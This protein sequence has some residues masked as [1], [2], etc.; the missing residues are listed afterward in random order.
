MLKYQIN[1]IKK[2]RKIQTEE[3]VEKEEE[4]KNVVSMK[5]ANLCGVWFWL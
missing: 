3:K 4:K 5:F 2:I 1:F